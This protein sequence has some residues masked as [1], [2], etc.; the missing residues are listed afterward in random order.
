MLG[1]A[2]MIINLTASAVRSR[3]KRAGVLRYITIR[4]GMSANRAE[5]E[6]VHASDCSVRIAV[7]N[8]DV[9]TFMDSLPSERRDE[10]RARMQEMEAEARYWA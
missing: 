9:H 7:E 10:E 4:A 8:R 2:P 3:A 6:Y 1:D 5:S